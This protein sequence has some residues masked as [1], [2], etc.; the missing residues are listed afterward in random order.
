MDPDVRRGRPT[1]ALLAVLVGIGVPAFAQD[2][3]VPLTSTS[4]TAFSAIVVVTSDRNASAH[5]GYMKKYDMPFYAV[6]FDAALNVGGVGGGYRG[7]RHRKGRR[8]ITLKQR[9]EICLFL[10]R[11]RKQLQDLMW[12]CS[13]I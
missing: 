12:A 3:F 9:I 4:S 7:F 6:P 1:V 11:G 2:G 10:R 5:Q 8:D 13:G